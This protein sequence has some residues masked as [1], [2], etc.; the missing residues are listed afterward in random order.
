MEIFYYSMTLSLIT[1]LISACKQVLRFFGIY[2]FIK[3]L[4]KRHPTPSSEIPYHPL[5]RAEKA[6]YFLDR[7][8]LGLEI[9]PSHNP[10]APKRLGFSV[11]VLDHLNAD[12]LRRKYADHSRFG[13]NLDNIEEVDYVWNGEDLKALTGK[14]SWYDWI[15]SSHVIEHIPNLVSHLQQCE[16]LIKNTGFISLVIPDMRYCFDHFSSVNLTGDF[17]DA[18]LQKSTRPTPG[19]IFNHFS[20][21]CQLNEK[22]C[23]DF[24]EA[25]SNY[26]LM[27]GLAD[28]K[29]LWEYAQTHD[30]YIDT[31]CWH[32]TPASFMLLISDLKYLGL[33]QSSVVGSF[34]TSGCEFYVTLSKSMPNDRPIDR[35]SLLIAIQDE[36]KA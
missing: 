12:G 18:Y 31:H 14:E 4:L 11:E 5:S 6:L 27:H 9:G 29:N 17:L 2:E 20:S 32:F 15:I 34:A 19:A 10:I 8:G 36:L 22:I 35:L 24:K 13:V 1:K 28:A 16:H 25:N 26:Q 23:W 21:A 33:I 30:E 3:K 7:K